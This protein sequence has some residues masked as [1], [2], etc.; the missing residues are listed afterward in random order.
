MH[1]TF[2]TRKAIKE[3]WTTAAYKLGHVISPRK[4]PQIITQ[5]T[6]RF[7]YC[8]CIRFYILLPVMFQNMLSMFTKLELQ[9]FLQFCSRSYIR[10]AE[11]CLLQFWF[12]QAI[13]LCNTQKYRNLMEL[14]RD[15]CFHW[16]HRLNKSTAINSWFIAVIRRFTHSVLN[17]LLHWH[18]THCCQLS[19]ACYLLAQKTYSIRCG[20]K[21][22]WSY[23]LYIF[24]SLISLS[25]SFPN[26]PCPY[27]RVVCYCLGL[28][29]LLHYCC[30]VSLR[31]FP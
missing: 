9:K 24:H 8:S 13:V 2:C 28:L 27:N 23:N 20:S 25:F 7:M 6:Q 3:H 30:R 12:A 14:S 22:L 18:H 15:K 1:A 29:T 10:V 26:V 4:I 31:F 19:V 11:D 5:K 16:W 17:N 21:Q